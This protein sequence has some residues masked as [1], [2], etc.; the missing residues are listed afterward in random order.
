[1]AF[2]LRRA[3]TADVA[4]LATHRRA[5]MEEIDNHDVATL[6]AHIGSYRGWLRSRLRSGS[7]AAWIA[8][9]D[10]TPAGS[11]LVFVLRHRPHPSDQTG[12]TPYLMGMYT[13][14]AYRRQGIA[15][16]IV[17]AAMGWAKTA[18]Y[19]AIVLHATDDGRKVYEDLGFKAGNEMW[20]SLE[21]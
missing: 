8:S 20:R 14:P 21:E 12:L 15:N 1:M 13:D 4:I 7:V 17:R 2:E 6:G 3:T 11:G 18:G 5:L 16:A 9:V 10:G 19:H